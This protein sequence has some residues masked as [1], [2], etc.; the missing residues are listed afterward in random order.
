MIP[1]IEPVL[2]LDPQNQIPAC[3]CEACGGER[4]AP[5]FTCL[6]CERRKE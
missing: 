4:Y 2:Y 6:R 1:L 5:T 3:F